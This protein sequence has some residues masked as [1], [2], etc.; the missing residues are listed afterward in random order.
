MILL[1][2]I[3]IIFDQ[4]VVLESSKLTIYEGVLTAIIGESG[5][6]KTSLLNL[7]GLDRVKQNMPYYYNDLSLSI[8]EQ[9]K[10]K[11]DHIFYIYQDENFV[12]YLTCKEHIELMFKMRNA[13]YTQQ[14]IDYLLN[15]VALQIDKDIYPATLSGGEKQRLAIAM[16]LARNSSLIICDEITASLDEENTQ[17]IIEILKELAHKENKM[18][19]L[20]THDSQVY[21]QCDQIYQIENKQLKLI[22][23]CEPSIQ[24]T[25]LNNVSMDQKIPLFLGVKSFFK[26][27][28]WRLIQIIL[29]TIVI[30]MCGV[31]Y[32][33][34]IQFT[35]HLNALKD[36]V[37]ANVY[38][39]THSSEQNPYSVLSSQ[40]AYTLEQQ[41]A[42][43]EIEELGE[44]FPYIIFENYGREDLLY[45]YELEMNG[46]KKSIFLTEEK[47]FGVTTISLP[48]Y[49]N[50]NLDYSCIGTINKDGEI[51]LTS[52][53]ADLLGI[54]EVREET[55]LTFYVNVPIAKQAPIQNNEM[56]I[57]TLQEVQYVI[58]GILDPYYTNIQGFY[59]TYL[60]YQDM[61]DIQQ[62]VSINEVYTEE[63]Q[64]WEPN[65]YI[66]SLD[67]SVDVTKI[68]E[69]LTAIDNNI[70]IYSVDDLL[71]SGVGELA[72]SEPFIRMFLII[73]FTIAVGLTIIFGYF[74]NKKEH[75]NCVLLKKRGFTN[76]QLLKTTGIK[77]LCHT[78]ALIALSLPLTL[79]VQWIADKMNL[80]IISAK[81]IQYSSE[82]QISIVISLLLSMILS[83]CTY[84]FEGV[85]ILRKKE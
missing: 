33:A 50:E 17:N 43:K 78:F 14:D 67:R 26:G 27:K 16:A 70:F 28:G 52:S 58:R 12:D 32:K 8:E 60:P 74:L 5:S 36:K 18:I 47:Q 24:K 37:N 55:K 19:V 41:E 45:Q 21:R 30:V 7:L 76:K 23:T 11:R 15:K 51:Y 85:D 83:I 68:Q 35:H 4:E 56:P 48:Y 22:K 9:E 73:F 65:A 80:V 71:D 29:M 38:Y 39:I 79:F 44:I 77:G 6:G 1:N 34:G 84:L 10:F 42:I 54:K 25:P 2:N 49:G 62:Q 31:G 46:V 66:T 64:K 69:K 72:S 57:Y 81:T 75:K 82:W 20:S 53:L 59:V 40:V 13:V 3:E 61:L 63:R